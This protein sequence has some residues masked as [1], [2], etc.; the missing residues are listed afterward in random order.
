ML[1][2]NSQKYRFFQR[3][4]VLK[5]NL[6]ESVP[7]YRKHATCGKRRGRGI[8]LCLGV[9]RAGGGLRQAAVLQGY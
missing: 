8:D 1:I 2:L 7:V 5:F 6:L 4:F 9:Q 3:G